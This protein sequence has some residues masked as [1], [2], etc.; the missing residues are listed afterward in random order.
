MNTTN[1]AVRDYLLG[2]QRRIV[3]A[4]EA[5]DGG[6]FITDHWRREP[7]GKTSAPETPAASSPQGEAPALGRPGVG[8]EGEGLSRLIEG[9]RVLELSLIHISEPTRPY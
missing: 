3:T 4:L 9:G 1:L 8:L 2:L 5:E 7:G 6:A